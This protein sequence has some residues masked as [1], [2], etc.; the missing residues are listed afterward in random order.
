MRPSTHSKS[1][2]DASAFGGQAGF[3]V[4]AWGRDEFD[5][6]ISTLNLIE[7]HVLSAGRSLA[8]DRYSACMQTPHQTSQ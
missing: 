3:G 5:A 2:L 8:A 7:G 6:E 4:P 1:R